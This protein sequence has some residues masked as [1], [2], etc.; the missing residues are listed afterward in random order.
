MEIEDLIRPT[1]FAGAPVVSV[2]A[3]TGT[4]LD[5]LKLIIEK[6]LKPPGLG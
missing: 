3:V 6:V 4:G 2:S 5:E 1:R